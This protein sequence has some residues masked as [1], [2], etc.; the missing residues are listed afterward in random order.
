[1][2]Y[3]ASGLRLAHSSAGRTTA[4]GSFP[5]SSSGLLLPS[6][7]HYEKGMKPVPLSCHGEGCN[8]AGARYNL[9]GTIFRAAISSSRIRGFSSLGLA[10]PE[11]N[12][13]K[14]LEYLLLASRSERSAKPVNN[15][16]T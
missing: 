1:M 15:E 3:S 12:E 7:F 10:E 9:R 11:P 4:R 16:P 2:A 6:S 8:S 13:A 14:P 5:L